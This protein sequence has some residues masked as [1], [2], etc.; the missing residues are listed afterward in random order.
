MSFVENE[1]WDFRN[2]Y[3]ASA[4]TCQRQRDECVA[5]ASSSRSLVSLHW[6]SG[7]MND[8]CVFGGSELGQ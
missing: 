1:L 8:R 4:A 2:M 7:D 3:Q 5:V 6:T